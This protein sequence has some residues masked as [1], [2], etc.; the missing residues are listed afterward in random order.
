MKLL[1]FL[2]LIDDSHIVFFRIKF[3]L[4]IKMSLS[5]KIGCEP[6]SRSPKQ[7]KWISD[8]PFGCKSNS[9]VN[10]PGSFGNHHVSI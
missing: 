6:V 4:K 7:S 10:V 9:N 2:Q 1:S 5:F 8:L 3:P